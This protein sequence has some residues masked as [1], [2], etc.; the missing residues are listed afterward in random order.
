[1]VVSE[2]RGGG[3]LES[4]ENSEVYWVSKRWSCGGCG[5]GEES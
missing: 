3:N 1:M 4:S 5:G 2:V